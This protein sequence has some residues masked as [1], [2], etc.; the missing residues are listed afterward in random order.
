MNVTASDS[1]RCT[2]IRALDRLPDLC[3][4]E[5]LEGVG[6][7][8][9]YTCAQAPRRLECGLCLIVSPTLYGDLA[10][11]GPAEQVVVIQRYGALGPLGRTV[12]LPAPVMA[13]RKEGQPL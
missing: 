12:V 5:S 7:R 8:E 2:V 4:C 3:L 1:A 13:Q 11:R 6:G 10:Q 9:L